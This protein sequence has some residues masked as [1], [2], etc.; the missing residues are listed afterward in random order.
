MLGGKEWGKY[1]ASLLNLGLFLEQLSGVSDAGPEMLR[2]YA[3][4]AEKEIA[5]LQSSR[6]LEVAEAVTEAIELTESDFPAI[7]KLLKNY[8]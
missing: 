7:E 3:K 8:L 2:Q 6:L 5:N 1:A 4:D